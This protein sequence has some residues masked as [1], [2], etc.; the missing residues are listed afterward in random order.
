[1]QKKI[2]IS[3][4]NYIPWR[5]YFDLIGYV[6]VFVFFDEV[7]F[8]RRDWRNRNK[9]ICNNDIKWLTIPLKNR[10]NYFES[11]LNMKVKD[12]KWIQDHLNKI[13]SYYNHLKNFRENFEIVRK[14]YDKINS[15]KLS[16]INQILIKEIC[17]VLEIKTKFYNSIEFGEKKTAKN[18]SA[19]LLEICEKNFASVYVSG[20]SAQNYLDK[21]I[22]SDKN[23][24]I[25]WFN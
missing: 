25:E 20:S 24:K 2:A 6:D 9:I 22:F 8:T 12:S 14:I 17:E 11:I 4:S 13:K 7:Q 19:R 3:Q 23:I 16:T 1:M 10:G 15:D 18:P 5:G 21:N